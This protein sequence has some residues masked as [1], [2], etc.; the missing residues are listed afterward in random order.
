MTN[1]IVLPTKWTESQ[2]KE[3]YW[4][5]KNYGFIL[6]KEE[7]QQ[8]N[9]IDAFYNG[10]DTENHYFVLDNAIE[11]Q[12]IDLC[13]ILRIVGWETT[14]E[15]PWINIEKVFRFSQ[16]ST[17]L[18]NTFDSLQ[19]TSIGPIGKPAD[20][21]VF[22]DEPMKCSDFIF[23]RL[24][25]LSSPILNRG[26]LCKVEERLPIL[27]TEVNE[28]KLR[29]IYFWAKDS[30]FIKCDVSG[31]YDFVHMFNHAIC[32]DE[33]VEKINWS[34]TLKQLSF[35]IE[36]ILKERPQIKHWKT[37]CKF[38][39][40][41]ENKKIS[42]NSIRSEYMDATKNGFGNTNEIEKIFTKIK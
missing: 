3:I 30:G 16:N 18:K 40:Y 9:F 5:I 31:L 24:D 35:F 14:N 28:D 11:K 1:K 37:V 21:S 27:E 15:I 20:M 17:S 4:R 19:Q 36:K 25:L 23:E 42:E 39:S 38:F 29:R 26:H 13:I 10:I 7:N 32:M 22:W 8:N 33:K 41:K 12:V 2:L 6:S 34:G